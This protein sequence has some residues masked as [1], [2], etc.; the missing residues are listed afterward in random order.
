[1]NMPGSTRIVYCWNF[2]SSRSH[3]STFFSVPSKNFEIL[4]KTNIENIT[5]MSLTKIERKIIEKRK[6][7]F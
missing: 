7:K 5:K 1:M 3:I 2:G 6:S 4:K